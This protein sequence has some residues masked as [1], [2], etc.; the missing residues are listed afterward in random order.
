MTFKEKLEREH[1]EALTD[2]RVCLECPCDYGYEQKYDCTGIDCEIC[3]N[4][5]IPDA[6]NSETEITSNEAVKHPPHYNTTSI[7]CWDALDAMVSSFTDPVEAALT[8]QVGKYIWRHPHK[9]KP[10]EDLKKA[11]DYLDRLIEREAANE[12]TTG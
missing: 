5:E 11:R 7:E 8:W 10:V 6:I 1:P 12:Q 2:E 4:R 9:G 3:W